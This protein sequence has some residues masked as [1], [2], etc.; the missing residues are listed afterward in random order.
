MFLFFPHPNILQTEER[1][2]NENE[3]GSM[4]KLEIKVE[5]IFY[6]VANILKTTDHQ[7]LEICGK[8]K[9]MKVYILIV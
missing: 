1:S 3:Y 8:E 5:L 9:V 6:V 7:K 2:I 4:M